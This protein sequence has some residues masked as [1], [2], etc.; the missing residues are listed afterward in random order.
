MYYNLF[1]SLNKNQVE[2]APPIPVNTFL[3]DLQGYWKFDESSGEQAMDSFVYEYDSIYNNTSSSVGKIN[4]AFEFSGSYV[5]LGN[6][7]AF[8]STDAFSFSGWVSGSE[9]SETQTIIANHIGSGSLRGYFFFIQANDEATPN[10]LK[11]V[12][13]NDA[14]S[15]NQIAVEGST[16]VPGWNHVA[17]TYDGSSTAEGVHLYLNS[18]ES[19]SIEFN[20]LSGSIISSGSLN[21]GI[22]SGSSYPFS[23]SMDE[24]GIWGKELSEYDTAIL[25]NSGSGFPFSNFQGD[26]P[27]INNLLTN[28]QSYW[29]LDEASGAQSLDSHA[30]NYDSVS[31]TTT[32]VAGILNNC[33]NCDGTQYVS[34]GNVLGYERTQPFS[35]SCWINRDNETYL[36]TIISKMEGAGDGRGMLLMARNVGAA[37]QPN[38]LYFLLRNTTSNYLAIFGSLYEI[39]AGSWYHIVVTYNGNSLS[40]GVKMYVNNQLEVNDVYNDNLS[41]TIINT[42]NFCIGARPTATTQYHM[43]KIDEVAFWDRELTAEEVELLYN[44]G[45]GFAY[46]GFS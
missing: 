43:G 35:F 12:L 36:N 40:T 21:F 25:Y 16:V 8:D 31:N 44:S 17:F 24:F 9:S 38:K 23:G 39:N 37:L 3:T 33:V 4:T 1:F 10:S 46:E 42:S 27:V 6:V 2:P 30:N 28:L 20:V 7:L 45:A 22:V 19:S 14:T 13:R 29:K 5:D 18:I 32:S 34:Y 26:T 15:E 41:N 11:L